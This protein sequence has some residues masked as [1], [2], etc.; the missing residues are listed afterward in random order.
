[1]ILYALW[2]QGLLGRLDV[3]K[4]RFFLGLTPDSLLL[5]RR[6][7]LLR[8]IGVVRALCSPSY[9]RSLATWLRYRI[10]LYDGI[11]G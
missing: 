10:E 9:A 2:R 11:Q 7:P 1:L 8:S 3:E 4:L 6:R 5:S